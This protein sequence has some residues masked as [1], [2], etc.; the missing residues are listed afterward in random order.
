M[1][2]D[3]KAYSS[4]E[5][6]QYLI[7]SKS[8]YLRIKRSLFKSFV[9]IYSY[10][11]RY[12]DKKET[13]RFTVTLWNAIATLQMVT[14][15]WYP[16]MSISGWSTYMWYWK[17]QAYAS[18]DR[19]C[20]SIGGGLTWCFYASV[21]IIGLNI[22]CLIFIAMLIFF[23]KKIH[24]LLIFFPGKWL[25][26]LVTIGN[27]PMLM[28]LAMFTKFSLIGNSVDQYAGIQIGTID[29]S[30]AA[31]SISI[32]CM[33]ICIGLSILGE[34]FSSETRHAYAHYNSLA[35]SRSLPDVLAIIAIEFY[36]FIYVYLEEN[37]LIYRFFSIFVIFMIVAYVYYINLPYYNLF[38]NQIKV[39]RFFIVSCT[40]LAFA[41]GTYLDSSGIILLLEGVVIPI[42]AVLVANQVNRHSANL[43]MSNP[44]DQYQLELQLRKELISPRNE[45]VSLVVDKISPYYNNPNFKTNKLLA[46]WEAYYCL[47][48][49]KDNRLAR[50]KLARTSHLAANLE[51]TFQELKCK[52]LLNIKEANAFEDVGFLMYLMKMSRAKSEDKKICLQ[53]LGF[54]EEITLRKP[55]IK[56]LQNFSKTISFQ[57]SMVKKWYLEIVSSYPKMIISR[58][59]YGTFLR[60]VMS[61]S[62]TKYLLGNDR[63]ISGISPG[64]KINEVRSQNLFTE[65]NGILWISAEIETLGQI[66][67]ANET[68]ASILNISATEL[69]GSKLSQYI[70]DPYCNGHNAKLQKFIDSCTSLDVNIPSSLMLR[71]PRGFLVECD[72]RSR[73]IALKGERYFIASIRK[74][75]TSRGCAIL[76]ADGA[77]HN[78]SENFASMFDTVQENL[79]GQLI[80][81]FI[82]S[83]M[84][85]TLK[86]FVPVLTILN[87][88]KVAIVH[89][90]KEF[91]N[92]TMNVALVVHDPIEI[93]QWEKGLDY[94]QGEY[95]RLKQAD[96]SFSEKYSDYKKSVNFDDTQILTEKILESIKTNAVEKSEKNDSK[97]FS[98]SS[99]LSKFHVKL[100]AG[101]QNELVKKS[102]LA[103][104]IF[105]WVLFWNVVAITIAS[106]SQLIYSSSQVSSA[107]SINSIR[108]LANVLYSTADLASSARLSDWAIRTGSSSIDKN[109][110][111]VNNTISNLI[112][113]NNDLFSGLKDWTECSSQNLISDQIIPNWELSQDGPIFKTNTMTDV[114]NKFISHGKNYIA[115]AYDFNSHKE[116]LYYIVMNGVGD[117][118]KFTNSSL[119]SLVSCEIS[120]VNELSSTI[121]LLLILSSL[122]LGTGIIVLI[123]FSFRISNIHNELWDFMVQLT[124]LVGHGLREKCLSRLSITH[125]YEAFEYAN[126]LI[127]RKHT[128]IEAN[129]PW[130]IITKLSLLF[131]FALGFEFTRTFVLY[132]T[133]EEYL[134]NRSSLLQIA[135]YRRALILELDIW[136][137][138]IPSL[139]NN[140]TLTDLFPESYRF[141]D[142]ETE[143]ESL[144]KRMFF[145]NHQFMQQK[146]QNLLSN[147]LKEFI[148]RQIG[149]QDYNSST[150]GSY[151]AYNMAILDSL[152]V[153]FSDGNISDLHY[154]LMNLLALEGDVID[155]I[156][157]DS[158]EKINA[159]LAMIT[160][161]SIMYMIFCAGACLLYY[162]PYLKEEKNKL[163]ELQ[164][165]IYL[166]QAP[167]LG[168]NRASLD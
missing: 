64:L 77:I 35:R 126:E 151:S 61:D 71:N 80:T 121:R 68:M 156:D 82:P 98:G 137:R 46:V 23:E 63:S 9:A 66:I 30:P 49:F 1:M 147:K 136:S 59:L 123:P 138:E 78:Y 161:V 135:T 89:T 166:L 21:G 24:P 159:Q 42:L 127:V 14:L 154:S 31:A 25:Q 88:K 10:K 86:P 92:L 13:R 130:L 7:S 45:Y 100:R 146:Y 11:Y 165:M 140:L 76:S 150:Y 67:Y 22:F 38:A 5:N 84:L 3:N 73:L 79:K 34:L 91:K 41:V 40:G 109:I 97:S 158:K 134:N 62:D 16:T 70:P 112:E 120:K 93:E 124:L 157:A 103:I 99:S 60:D 153:A 107:S 132:Q 36:I 75:N 43:D 160:F 162:F 83:Y 26:F 118:Y 90:V 4:S 50:I 143:Y 152:N 139:K 8:L 32:V 72:L 94:D 128:V 133:C 51:S 102:T 115:S 56:R 149:S 39:A 74:I 168:A 116:D 55:N 148:Y 167:L 145:S 164:S 144:L 58:E 54:L 163:T 28:I 122:V 19:I 12:Q 117:F 104:T 53:V 119:A 111:E 142:I 65:A 20:A 17:A 81:D 48:A 33:A 110:K 6:Q 2:I 108:N 69:A 113:V 44:V 57:V 129:N 27:I 125:G 155:G 85:I 96:S 141:S 87:Q 114:L 131:L 105:Q 101:V 52:Q 47:Y 37:L 106:I 15:I 95:R 18:F 29:V